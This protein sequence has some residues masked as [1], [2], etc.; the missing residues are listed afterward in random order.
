MLHRSHYGRICSSVAIT[1]SI[2]GNLCADSPPRYT[3]HR[4]PTPPKIDGHLEAAVWDSVPSVG[5]FRFPWWTDGKREQTRA[6][7]LWDNDC[8]I[9]G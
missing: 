9:Y 4:T 8:Y 6:R 7:L 1:L 5:K 2:Y 3:I